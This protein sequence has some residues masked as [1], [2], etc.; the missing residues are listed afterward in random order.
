[1]REQG[2]AEALFFGRITAGITHEFKNVLAIIKE[3][4]G[5][6]EDILSVTQDS[7]FPHKEKFAKTL[8]T[9]QTQ[10]NRGVELSTRLNTFA[11]S[12]DQAIASV[13]LNELVDQVLHLSHRFARSRNVGLNLSPAPSPLLIETGPV[14][15]QMVLFACIECC[16]IAMPPGGQI[17]F[18]PQ[19]KGDRKAIFVQCEGDLPS[20]TEFE[21]NLTNARQ[22][23]ELR[24]IIGNLGGEALVD[25][26]IHGIW[27]YLPR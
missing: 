20:K 11:H 26:A 25:E 3:S 4:S 18:S 16:L 6:L 8:A 12:P 1:L 24:D 9:I 27:I 19:D 15:L 7:G 17:S 10:V 21:Q 14:H 22:W 23:S 13:D 2:Q 5:L